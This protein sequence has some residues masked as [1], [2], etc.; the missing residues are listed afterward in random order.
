MWRHTIQ[1]INDV[2]EECTASILRAAWWAK[3]AAAICL[4]LTHTILCEMKEHVSF[5]KTQ[6]WSNNI[7]VEPAAS[8]LQATRIFCG[9]QMVAAGCNKLLA[10]PAGHSM[11]PH[12]KTIITVLTNN[13]PE[14]Q[15]LNCPRNYSSFS[16]TYTHNNTRK[17]FVDSGVCSVVIVHLWTKNHWVCILL[18]KLTLCRW[19]LC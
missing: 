11:K 15:Q 9:L 6:D 5:C 7:S 18:K 2:T 19:V 4:P 14:P 1:Y 10:P 8:C 12:Q 17:S 13:S 16:Q 3:Q